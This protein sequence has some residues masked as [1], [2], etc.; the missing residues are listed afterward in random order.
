MYEVCTDFL[1]TEVRDLFMVSVSFHLADHIISSETDNAV[2][3]VF[4]TLGD[5]FEVQ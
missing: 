4:N 2:G 1:F 5:F 3:K